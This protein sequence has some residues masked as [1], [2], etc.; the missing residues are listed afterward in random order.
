MFGC[1]N[2]IAFAAVFALNTATIAMAAPVV[3]YTVEGT[4]AFDSMTSTGD[5][6]V[7]ASIQS[8]MPNGTS[9]TLSINLDFGT[10]DSD[11]TAN[12]GLYLLA[13][14][15]STAT[16]G[17]FAFTPIA[18]PCVNPIFD[19]KVQAEKD[20]VPMFFDSYSMTSEVMS[21]TALSAAIAPP[22]TPFFGAS[23]FF[24]L[25]AGGQGL[26]TNDDMID[27]TT[28]PFTG[29]MSVAFPG[30]GGIDI[31]RYAYNISNIYEGVPTSNVD[32]PPSLGLFGLGLVGLAIAQR[33]RRAG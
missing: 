5:P 32:T 28:L 33:R 4:L 22:A 16:A 31:A 3:T 25:S 10:A 27:P 29:R 19:C 13:I 20:L 12:T 23:V 9:V 30:V 14:S 15:G 26:L 17:G 1:R 8:A 24:F 11:P 6:S 18:T 2:V 21:S 7:L